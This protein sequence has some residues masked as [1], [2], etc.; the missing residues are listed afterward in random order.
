[1]ASKID[2]EATFHSIG[3]TYPG[4]PS[5]TEDIMREKFNRLKRQDGSMRARLLNVK[6]TRKN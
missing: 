1:M 6:P 4:Y 5:T 3:E 2:F